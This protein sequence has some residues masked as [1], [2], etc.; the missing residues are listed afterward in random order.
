MP[1][2]GRAAGPPARHRHG[3]PAPAGASYVKADRTRLK[4][5]LINLLFNAIKYNRPRAM[6]RWSVPSP[7]PAPRAHQRA[8]HRR[9][10][11]TE[12]VE[13]AVP[14]LQPPGPGGRHEEGTG[15]G[16]VVTQRLVDADGRQDRRRQHAGRGQRV[17]G[18]NGPGVG[19]RSGAGD[20]RRAAPLPGARRRGQQTTLLYVE[21]N[22][23]NL[24]LV[25]QIIARRSN[26]RLLGAAD[27]S[28]GIE[29]AR[30]YSPR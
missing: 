9:R 5:V 29:F 16:L 27:A 15:I 19:T 30:V 7:H 8:R 23:A 20:H 4:Q 21:D 25:E 6:C 11:A 13:P 28:L 10:P 1:R 18:R 22:P 24:E 2:H 17:L 3:F 14:A 12:Q 26:L